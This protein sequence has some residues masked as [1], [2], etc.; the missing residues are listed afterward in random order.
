[1]GPELIKSAER[2]KH[3]REQLSHHVIVGLLY[4]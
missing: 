4:D 3:L 2:L 1:M